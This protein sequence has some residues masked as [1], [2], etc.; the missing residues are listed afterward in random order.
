MHSYVFY[1]VDS[2]FIFQGETEYVLQ[3][4]DKVVFIS[5]LHGG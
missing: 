4:N 1:Y 5:T 3:E 2:L